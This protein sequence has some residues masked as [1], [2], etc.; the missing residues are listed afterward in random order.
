MAHSAFAS[1]VFSR[2]FFSSYSDG[3]EGSGER[4]RGEWSEEE[5]EEGE[6][7]SCRIKITIKVSFFFERFHRTLTMYRYTNVYLNVI[8]LAEI[9]FFIHYH[10]C[11]LFPILI[12]SLSLSLSLSHSL[13][14]PLSLS[15]CSLF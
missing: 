6:G 4:E 15:L 7:E 5:E 8:Y 10:A 12:L 2:G 3:L 11:M 13:P 14:F 9:S 1:F